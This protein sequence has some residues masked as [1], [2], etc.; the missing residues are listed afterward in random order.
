MKRAWHFL[1]VSLEVITS[2][3]GYRIL[4]ELDKDDSR[5]KKMKLV[6]KD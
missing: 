1:G 4:Q 2:P 3:Q 6:F 5:D